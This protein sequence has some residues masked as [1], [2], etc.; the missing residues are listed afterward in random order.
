LTKLAANFRSLGLYGRHIMA[1]GN[2][3]AVR[4]EGIGQGKNGQVVTFWG[5]DVIR[6]NPAGKIQSVYAFWDPTPVWKAIGAT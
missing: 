6:V 5:I 2:D 4:W 3:A 1:V